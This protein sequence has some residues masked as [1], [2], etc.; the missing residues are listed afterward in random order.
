MRA[1]THSCAAFGCK[2][3]I[4]PRQLFCIVHL[5]LVPTHLRP[6]LNAI[7]TSRGKAAAYALEQTK[8]KIAQREGL[9]L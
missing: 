9:W 5:R 1:S 6:G 8:I 4:P 3:E 7:L 2:A